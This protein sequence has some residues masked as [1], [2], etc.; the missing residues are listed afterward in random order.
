MSP[1]TSFECTEITSS[2]L[3]RWYWR[4]KYANLFKKSNK[5]S[6]S[7]GPQSIRQFLFRFSPKDKLAENWK[8]I[9][10]YGKLRVTWRTIMGDVGRVDLETAQR[11]VGSYWVWVNGTNSNAIPSLLKVH[12]YGNLRLLSENVPR[13]ARLNQLFT[14]VFRVQN[15]SWVNLH[16]P[17]LFIKMS[18][19]PQTVIGQWSCDSLLTSPS[20]LP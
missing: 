16:L 20:S 17:F 11:M 6:N 3:G 14:A 15:C 2:P 10:D 7:L 8:N 5:F 4:R 1:A 12:G 18:I 19:F 9:V 13:R